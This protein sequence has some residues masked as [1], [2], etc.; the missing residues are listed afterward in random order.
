MP[1]VQYCST[2]LSM[3]GTGDIMLQQ[4]KFKYG[5]RAILN[6]RRMENV[7]GMLQEM[8]A[9]PIVKHCSV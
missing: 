3:V 1:H 8:H 5:P 7:N 4:Q 2:V 6:L 9:F